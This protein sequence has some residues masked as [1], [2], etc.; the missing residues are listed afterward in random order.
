MELGLKGQ[1]AVV[2]GSAKGIGMAIAETFAQ[3]G[4][5]LF[6]VDL[7]DQVGQVAKDIS[8]T[9][10]IQ[11]Q[12]A[13]ANVTDNNR[14]KDLATEAGR[15]FTRID[16]IVYA[17]GIGSGKFGF[18]FWNLTPEDWPKVLQVNVIGAVNVA[19]AFVPSLI[20]QKSG[21]MTFLASV[22]GQIGSQTD[23]PYSASKAALIN[24]SQ[25]AAKDLAPYNVRVNSVCPGMVKT[26]LNRSVWES[27]NKQQPGE[28]Q[29]SY[30]DWAGEKIRNVV[31]LNRWQETEDIA[32][33]VVFLASPKPTM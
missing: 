3:E 33:M 20:E 18:P 22:S 25:C 21:T 14:L 5:N 9:Y 11:C 6:L 24:F 17:V 7:D 29:R 28:Q 16:H 31:P 15:L 4:T 10:S 27:W 12:A 23:P 30:E 26:A 2:V 19:H 8:T 32:R 13:V 1:T